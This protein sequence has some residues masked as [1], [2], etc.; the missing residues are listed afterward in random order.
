VWVDGERG[1]GGVGVTPLRNSPSRHGTAA[2]ARPSMC[3]TGM[4]SVTT[5]HPIIDRIAAER[6]LGPEGITKR[7]LAGCLTLCRWRNSGAMRCRGDAVQMTE[8]GAP[9]EG[10]G[11][12]LPEPYFTRNEPHCGGRCAGGAARDA[13]RIGVVLCDLAALL[14]AARLRGGWQIGLEDTPGEYI[15]A[16]VRSSGSFAAA[17]RRRMSS[18]KSGDSYNGLKVGNTLPAGFGG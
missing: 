5:G 2:E 18:V 15:D 14:F 16:L 17:P 7:D 1:V 8:P 12:T 6:G 11:V 9:G 10:G 4:R 3:S 13:R